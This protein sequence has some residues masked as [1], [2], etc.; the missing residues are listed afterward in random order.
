[1]NTI[2]PY[3]VLESDRRRS[4][5]SLNI[6]YDGM[7]ETSGCEKCE[8]VNQENAYW[9]CLKQSPSMYYVEFLEVWDEM[10]TW[11]K[12]DKGYIIVRAIKNYL[13]DD[14]Q[15]GCIFYDDKC[16]VYKK[17]PY[18]CRIYGV[19]PEEN[20]NKRWET[21][22]SREGESFSSLP[23]CNLVTS[24]KPIS[25]KQ[26]DKWFQHTQDTERKLGLSELTIR[27]HDSENGSYHT[28]HDHLLL[29][30]FPPETLSVLTKVKL[31][32][33]SKNDIENFAEELYNTLREANVL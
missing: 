5:I 18:Q 7:P 14:K 8:E 13:T 26:D 23:Q 17:R 27:A 30:L 28:F 20:W 4:R 29:E 10:R 21:L 16:L 3:N 12:Q 19:I 32:K 6:L 24:E 15:K 33:P 1:M 22:K 25:A 9:C 31:T 11:S 2:N